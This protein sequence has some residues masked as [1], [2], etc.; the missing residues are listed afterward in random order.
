MVFSLIIIKQNIK[1]EI[2]RKEPSF[3][4]TSDSVEILIKK[5]KGIANKILAIFDPT[6][7]P[8]VI[9]SKSLSAAF[10]EIASSGAEV[11]NATKVTAITNGCILRCFANETEPLTKNSPLKY[12][13]KTP[14][15]R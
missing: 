7:F 3:F 13:M 2:I 12:S 15:K 10:T 14:T 9:P 1:V 6:I 11:P 4:F 5:A 8:K